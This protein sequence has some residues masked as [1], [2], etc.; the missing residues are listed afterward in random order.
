M[1]NY[2]VYES[3]YRAKTRTFRIWLN[4]LQT[5]VQRKD[6]LF[7]LV[8]RDYLSDYKRS[9][10]SVGWILITPA[11]GILSWLIINYT[12]ILHP[13]QL[14]IPYPAYVLISTM[15]W[16]LFISIYQ[17]IS[18][19]F[20][21]SAS[22]SLDVKSLREVLIVKQVILQTLNLAVG[23]IFIEIVLVYYGIYP[24]WKILTFPLTLL[25]LILMG[26][27]IGL[28]TSVYSVVLPDAKKW[29]DYGMQLLMFV[30]PVIYSP[31]VSNALIRKIIAVNPISY[32][33]DWSRASLI[34]GS[35]DDPLQ[36][37]V[38]AIGAL[39]IFLS[40]IRLLYLAEDKVIEKI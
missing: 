18:N 15:I 29:L 6:L 26:A 33:L 32:L 17:S 14:P 13:G 22:F 9:F 7:N 30:T 28:L 31:Q 37:L 20:F 8:K 40:G 5:V 24:T 11:L 10:I 19:L 34:C 36:F 39:L 35:F 25:P 16:R 1:S 21:E 3:N 2:A 38:S 27:G 23:L 4:Y 12:N